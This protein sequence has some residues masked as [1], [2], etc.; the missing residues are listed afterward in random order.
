MHGEKSANRDD[1][2]Y[3]EILAPKGT[4]DFLTKSSND[5]WNLS[6]KQRREKTKND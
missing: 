4:P 5:L 2:V 6:K 1:L 3:A